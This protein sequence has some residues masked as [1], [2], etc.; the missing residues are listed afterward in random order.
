MAEE[1]GDYR[2]VD[3]FEIRLPKGYG[4][5]ETLGTLPGTSVKLFGFSAKEAVQGARP[6]L[7]FIV[8]RTQP[9]QK[10][11]TLDH[12]FEFLVLKAASQ[13]WEL[14]TRRHRAGEDWR[15]DL[16]QN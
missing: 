5:G 6:M 15:S 10:P 9:G 1:L 14:A 2:D 4:G 8:Q 11:E 16:P 3:G 12:N 7:S 13:R